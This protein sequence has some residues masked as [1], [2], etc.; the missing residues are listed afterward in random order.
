M[1]EAQRPLY[2]DANVFLSYVEGTPGRAA[3]IDGLIVHL[4]E[5]TETIARAARRIV[6]AS[7][8]AGPTLKP[9]DAIHLAMA[10]HMS[11]AEMHTYD[12]TLH[13]LSGRFGFP[14]QEPS[15]IPP[16]RGSKRP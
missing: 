14:I 12:A 2:W 3:L 7:I 10:L 6:R 13:K 15:S 5:V 11:V 16:T 1:S 9:M 4:I 8:L